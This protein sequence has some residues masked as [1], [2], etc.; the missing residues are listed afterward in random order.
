[1]WVNCR[2]L[3]QSTSAFYTLEN[4][5]IRTS[6]FY[7]RPTSSLCPENTQTIENCGVCNKS[8]GSETESWIACEVSDGWF[9]LRCV[10]NNE[11]SYKL[12]KDRDT[13]HWYCTHCNEKIG[14]IIANMVRL[15]D[16]WTTEL[17][18]WKLN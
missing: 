10:N 13:C 11:E 5:Q 18:K 16:R 8:T 1:V 7:H 2:S 4:P 3:P 17:Q 12:L 6:A 9:H 14:K 15:Y